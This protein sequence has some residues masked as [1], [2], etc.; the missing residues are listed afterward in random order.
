MS[1]SAAGAAGLKAG[2]LCIQLNWADEPGVWKDLEPIVNDESV[3]DVLAK[4]WRES[5]AREPRVPKASLRTGIC[6]RDGGWNGVPSP[7]FDPDGVLA[8]PSKFASFPSIYRL[9]PS[10]GP[11]ENRHV[12]LAQRSAHRHSR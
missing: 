4:M 10:W 3:D 9:P 2:D 11:K 5:A 7:W 1:T 6:R 8:D 12:H